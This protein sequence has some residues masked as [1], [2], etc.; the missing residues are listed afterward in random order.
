[1]S[2]LVV[3]ESPFAGRGWWLLAWIRRLLNI[4]FAR[5]CVRHSLMR[6]EQPLASHLLYT[7]PG[8][9]RDGNPREREQGI[10]AGLAWGLHAKLWVFYVDRG[11]S[12]GMRI[13]ERYAYEAGIVIEYRFLRLQLRG[14]LGM[15]GVP[16]PMRKVLDDAWARLLAR[17]NPIAPPSM[18]TSRA[19]IR[20]F[21][22][23]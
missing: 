13:A 10:N 9:L 2:T 21:H 23:R 16:W 18:W 6:D 17:P 3:V 20:F 15:H 12:F 1:M 22:G 11:M 4:R 8:I 7:Q 14:R 5:A 19:A